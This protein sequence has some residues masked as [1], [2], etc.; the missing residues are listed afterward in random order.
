LEIGIG[1]KGMSNLVRERTMDAFVLLEGTLSPSEARK[2]LAPGSYGVVLDKQD[3][4]IALIVVEDLE[5]AASHDVASLLD[6]E[7][8]LS[9]AV[10]VGSE[11][12]MQEL[13][14]SGAMTVFDIGAQGAVVLGDEGVVGVLPVEAIEEYLGSGEYKLPTREMGPS[15]V[16][17]DANLGGEHQTPLG[18]MLCTALVD[19]ERCNYINEMVFLDKDHMPICQN[20]NLPSHT[21][22]VA[23]RE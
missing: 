19:S 22:Q 9:P 17:G 23:H 14:E 7:A 20:P 16:S 2:R 13:V 1:G 5:Q 4:P 15:A 10:V 6:S 8:S 18:K 21:L 12:Q 3:N 11:I